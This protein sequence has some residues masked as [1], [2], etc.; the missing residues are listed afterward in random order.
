MVGWYFRCEGL[1]L[2]FGRLCCKL[3]CHKS[4]VSFVLSL[5][6]YKNYVSISASTDC[7]PCH[8]WLYSFLPSTLLAWIRFLIPNISFCARIA[9]VNWYIITLRI[10]K[11]TASRKKTNVSVLMIDW[12]SAGR[13]MRWSKDTMISITISLRPVETWKSHDGASLLVA[14]WWERLVLQP[15]EMI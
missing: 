13:T 1:G 14:L 3:Q 6:W 10:A 15:I 2:G 5:H 7:I 4:Q 9:M 8:F 11:A 12:V